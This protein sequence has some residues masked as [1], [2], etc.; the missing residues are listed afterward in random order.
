MQKNFRGLGH[1][2]VYTAKRKFFGN[3]YSPYVFF[4]YRYAKEQVPN[5][6]VLVTHNCH[7][8]DKAAQCAACFSLVCCIFMQAQKPHKTKESIIEIML[9]VER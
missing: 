3:S 7:F 8:R 4:D 2:L 1:T 6:L 9:F 5:S